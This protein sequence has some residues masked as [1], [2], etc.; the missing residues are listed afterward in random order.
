MDDDDEQKLRELLEDFFT[1]LKTLLEEEEVT[2]PS[3]ESFPVSTSLLTKRVLLEI[4][5]HEGIVREAYRDSKG[6]WTWGIGVTDASGHRVG[7]YKDNPQPIAR[8]VEIFKWLLETKYLPTVLEA[9]DK[10]LTEAQLAAALSFHYNTGSIAR[11]SWVKSFN[12]GNLIKAKKEIM[13]WV[14]PAEIAPRRRKER[15]LFFDG[16][17]SNDGMATVYEKV[18]KPSYTPDWKS[19]KKIDIAKEF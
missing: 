12:S 4:I 6:I 13:N 18:N 5:C 11:A 17:W 16:V 8:V 1:Q 7:R 10:P 2:S 9:F 15:D 3:A 14:K 19:A